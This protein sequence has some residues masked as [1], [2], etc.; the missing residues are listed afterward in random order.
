MST[1]QQNWP[2]LAGIPREVLRCI[3]LCK[4]KTAGEVKPEKHCTASSQCKSKLSL[5]MGIHLYSF[6][7]SHTLLSQASTSAKHHLTRQLP[8]KQHVTQLS[9][10]RNQKFP[11]TYSIFISSYLHFNLYQI[12][13]GKS[14]PGLRDGSTVKN[15]DCF[16]RGPEFNSQ[17]PHGGS[18]PSGI[19]SDALF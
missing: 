4:V 13:G 2:E 19:G 11:L 12:H 18:Q 3:S 17:Q 10:Q 15:I 7:K 16:S 5:F 14:L 9:S 8:E 6:Q 1:S